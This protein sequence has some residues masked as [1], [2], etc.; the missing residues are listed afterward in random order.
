LG[1]VE[2]HAKIVVFV[3][4]D[5]VQLLILGVVAFCNP[6]QKVCDNSGIFVTNEKVI[7]ALPRVDE[8]K[9]TIKSEE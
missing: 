2:I 6:F 8:S 7:N 5:D 3:P 4:A 9:A 1:E